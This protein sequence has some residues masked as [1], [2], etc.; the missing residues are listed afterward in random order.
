MRISNSIKF[1]LLF[2]KT[3]K[4]LKYSYIISSYKLVRFFKDGKIEISDSNIKG[5]SKIITSL[6]K[7]PAIFIILA[8]MV[9][10]LIVFILILLKKEDVYSMNI[11]IERVLI[12]SKNNKIL[13][14]LDSNDPSIVNLTKEILYN[15]AITL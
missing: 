9:A 5:E 8:W 7:S 10:C 15:K 13:S 2:F 14:G 3:F 4:L 11:T 12:I 1:L 6:L